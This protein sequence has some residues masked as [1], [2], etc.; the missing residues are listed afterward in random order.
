MHR[1]QN[2][3]CWEVWGFDFFVCLALKRQ[4]WERGWWKAGEVTG[5][6]KQSSLTLGHWSSE[7]QVK[8]WF[9][10][11]YLPLSSHLSSPPQ[12]RQKH[13]HTRPLRWCWLSGRSE[14]SITGK[15]NIWTFHSWFILLDSSES[16]PCTKWWR[17]K[18]ETP[19]KLVFVFLLPL[20]FRYIYF[21][22]YFPL[23]HLS[24]LKHVWKS[25]W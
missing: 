16:Y 18:Y 7:V 3:F 15:P 25:R 11:F 9:W 1:K 24:I 14:T 21:R 19:L 5:D 4:F 8:F 22:N 17:E 2:T 13:E 23:I 6:L 12:T 10:E 20:L